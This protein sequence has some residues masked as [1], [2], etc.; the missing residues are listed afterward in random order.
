MEEIVR[1]FMEVEGGLD[2]E[3]ECGGKVIGIV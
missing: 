2:D 1:L 3:G